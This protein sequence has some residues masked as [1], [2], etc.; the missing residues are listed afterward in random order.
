MTSWKKNQTA[1]LYNFVSAPVH[2]K[3]DALAEILRSICKTNSLLYNK[4]MDNIEYRRETLKG[5]V[6][7]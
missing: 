6:E 2:T 4:V 1:N 5:I 7:K 3:Q